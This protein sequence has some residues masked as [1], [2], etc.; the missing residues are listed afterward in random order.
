MWSTDAKRRRENDTK[1]LNKQH[2]P[3][4]DTTHFNVTTKNVWTRDVLKNAI[5]KKS[6]VLAAALPLINHPLHS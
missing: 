4:T 2:H 3:E 6:S 1:S 5:V